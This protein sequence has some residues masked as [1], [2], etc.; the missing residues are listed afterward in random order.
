MNSISSIWNR[1]QDV[2]VHTKNITITKKGFEDFLAMFKNLKENNPDHYQIINFCSVALKYDVW[3]IDEKEQHEIESYVLKSMGIII[4]L[5][6]FEN[7]KMNFEKLNCFDFPTLQH[8][9]DVIDLI[10]VIAVHRDLTIAY[11]DE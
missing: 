11:R 8:Y 1:K 6:K 7:C 3:H 10:D 4:W 9:K 5:F 2:K